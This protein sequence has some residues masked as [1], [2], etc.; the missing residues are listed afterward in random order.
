ML[1][2]NSVIPFFLIWKLKR[3]IYLGQKI[4]LSQQMA[5]HLVYIFIWLTHLKK[6]EIQI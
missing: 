6:E 2:S 3:G 1:K 4:H 5:E